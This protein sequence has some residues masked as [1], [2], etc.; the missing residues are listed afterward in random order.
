MNWPEFITRRPNEN[1]DVPLWRGK[2]GRVCNKDSVLEKSDKTFEA[3]KRLLCEIPL[4]LIE[5]EAIAIAQAELPRS[6]HYVEPFLEPLSLFIADDL[7]VLE[8]L[9]QINTEVR[10]K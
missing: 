1:P 3:I 10:Y 2:I 5:E 9:S 6:N 8:R 7:G 4:P